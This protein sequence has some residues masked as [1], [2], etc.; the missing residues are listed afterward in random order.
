MASSTT[1]A[2]RVARVSGQEAVGLYVLREAGGTEGGG[3]T[4]ARESPT[5][6]TSAAPD[7]RSTTAASPV[8]P[9]LRH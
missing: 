9:A 8:D 4:T 1:A 2:A 7:W 6:P 5:C 3:R